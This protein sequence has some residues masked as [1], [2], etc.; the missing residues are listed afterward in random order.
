M[1][2]SLIVAVSF[3]SSFLTGCFVTQV[4][5]FLTGPNRAAYAN[6]IILSQFLY[7]QLPLCSSCETIQNSPPPSLSTSSFLSMSRLLT[8]SSTVTA[9]VVPRHPLDLTQ[10]GL[11]QLL[12][13]VVLANM[14]VSLKGVVERL[15]LA[16]LQN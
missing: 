8:G 1:K 12:H 15:L 4:F 16:V 14:L 9:D 3:L 2:F 5:S 13:N 6:S 10:D 11:G 7:Y